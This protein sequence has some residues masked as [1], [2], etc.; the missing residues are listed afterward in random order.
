MV[1]MVTKGAG[2]VIYLEN[3]GIFCRTFGL[4][5]PAFGLHRPE[6]VPCEF[7]ID[8]AIIL[9][10]VSVFDNKCM[11]D[12]EEVYG[13]CTGH[14]PNRRLSKVTL[15]DVQRIIDALC[16]MKVTFERC[17]TAANFKMMS[18]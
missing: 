16:H 7:A 13:T 12:V 5:R 8:E 10:I 2:L 18:L 4:H 3:L 14:C 15:D 1:K 9:Q 11:H 6:E 17:S